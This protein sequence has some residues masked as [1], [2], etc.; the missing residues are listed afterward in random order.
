[1]ELILEL[2]KYTLPALV[3][4]LVVYIM[5]KSH[6]D[7]N[8]KLKLLQLKSDSSKEFLPLKLQAYERITLFVHRVAPENIIPRI[9]QPG[10]NAQ[11]L[12]VAMIQAIQQEFEHNITQQVYV[13][14]VVWTMVVGYKNSFANLINAKSKQLDAN[15]TAYDL[16][17]LII[18][19]YMENEELLSAPKVQ[20]A[21]K[22]EV[23]SLFI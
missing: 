17:K 22:M 23:K 1:M 12:K 15:A 6:Q 19:E 18:E 21:I 3:V 11:M 13:S 9:Q 16:G 10:M 14:N 7:N 2:L 8:Y 4:A 20:E 5:L